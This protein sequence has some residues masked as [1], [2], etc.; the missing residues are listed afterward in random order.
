MRKKQDKAG[1]EMPGTSQ[2]I[3]PAFNRAD[4]LLERLLCHCYRKNR[5]QGRP[6]WPEGLVLLS[7]GERII[8]MNLGTQYV[9]YYVT[10]LAHMY[11]LH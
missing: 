9:E 5:A 2:N 7:P 3:Y 11:Y 6:S 1:E 8:I 10:F 4:H